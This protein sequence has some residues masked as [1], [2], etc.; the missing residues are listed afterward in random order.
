MGVSQ[1][2]RPEMLVS[3]QQPEY[4]ST[5]LKKSFFGREAA[6]LFLIYLFIFT[7]AAGKAL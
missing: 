2:W 6:V 4:S 3:T 7:V 5:F 1:D